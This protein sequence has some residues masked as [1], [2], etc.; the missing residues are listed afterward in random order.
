MPENSAASPRQKLIAIAGPTASGKSALAVELCLRI[1]GEVLSCDSMMVYRGMDIGTAKVTAAE[2]RGVPHHLLDLTEPSQSFSAAD[3]REAARACIADVARRGR[4][5]VMCG[6]TGL[7]LDAVTRDMSLAHASADAEVRAALEQELAEFGAE[8][9]H[10]R[11]AD[12]DP[13]SAAALHVNDTR[14]VMRALEIYAVTGKPASEQHASP[15]E[16]RELYDLKLCALRPDRAWLYA[17][18]D[19]RVDIMVKDGLIDEVKALLAGGLDSNCTAMQAIGYKEIVSALSGEMSVG[20]AIDLIKQR[21]RN[22]AKR[23][24]SWLRRDSRTLWL[25]VYEH[26]DAAALCDRLI[27]LVGED[28]LATPCG[29]E[30]V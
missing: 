18:I 19:R 10:A 24:L 12:V 23:Q 14:R 26:D 1:G 20:E 25:D 13:T 3:Y 30:N 4:L 5:P 15:D 16:N 6:G 22:Y 21:S 9:L 27:G 17:R 7:Y 11:L 2:T 8:A 29:G 28:W